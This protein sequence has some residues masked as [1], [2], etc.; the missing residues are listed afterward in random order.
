MDPTKKNL[1]VILFGASGMVGAAILN[2]CLR[3]ENVTSILAVG[4]R[5]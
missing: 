2:E 1:K 4:R 3:D 5:N